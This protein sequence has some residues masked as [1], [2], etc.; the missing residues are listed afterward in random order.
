[1]IAIRL[2]FFRNTYF[3]VNIFSGIIGIWHQELPKALR[4]FGCLVVFFLGKHTP[5]IF[6]NLR[7][8]KNFKTIVKKR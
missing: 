6:G 1:M 4:V 5:H 2:A 3:E 8:S 7:T